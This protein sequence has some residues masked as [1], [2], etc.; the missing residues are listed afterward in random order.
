M[1]ILFISNEYPPETGFG[2]IATYS[3]HAAEGLAA[4]GHG[5]QVICRSTDGVNRTLTKNGVVVHRV[6]PG[7]YRLPQ[8]RGFFLLRK[9][10]YLCIPQSLVRL[11]WAATVAQT[12]VHLAGEG[13]AFDIIEYPEC[14]AEGLHLAGLGCLKGCA[15]VARLHTPWEII[16][17]LD[18]LKEPFFDVQ[19]QS[20][21]ERLSVHRANAVS[22]PSQAIAARLSKPW[23]LSSVKVYP[24]PLPVSRYSFTTGRDW[25]YVGRIERRKGVHLLIDAYAATCAQRSPPPL[26]LVGRP[27]GLLPCGRPYGDF[28]R[29]R[30]RESGMYERIRWVEGVPQGS[31]QEHLGRSSVAFFPSLWENFPYAC[32]EAM[33]SGCAVVASD[34]GG[35]PEM[36]N[37]DK[38]GLLFEPGSVSALAG[39]MCRIMDE[40]GLARRLGLKAREFAAKGCDQPVVCAQA[41]GF[42]Q[43]LLERRNP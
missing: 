1:N 5:V 40:D 22:A 20:R 3:L 14:G 26:H 32:I 10:C 9:L 43:S 2:G 38:N 42:Y 39:A 24:N 31:V 30:I 11:A 34:C 37:H 6:V 21:I 4:R 35:F 33:A 12:C 8:G 18:K 23:R 25:L 29:E 16:H 28:I 36:I 41:E 7:P 19:L 15:T 27:Y 17:S 13:S